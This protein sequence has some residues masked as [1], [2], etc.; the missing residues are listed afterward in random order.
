MLVSF[1]CI[2][3]NM[4]IEYTVGT[5]RLETTENFGGSEEQTATVLPTE[6]YRRST[7][8]EAVALKAR[9]RDISFNTV[10]RTGLL[11]PS[12]PPIETSKDA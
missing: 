3:D 2:D 1:F 12:Q 11:A 4:W 9:M 7:L 5:V 6:G 10:V 8:A